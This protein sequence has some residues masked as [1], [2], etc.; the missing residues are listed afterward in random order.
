VIPGVTAPSDNFLDLVPVRTLDSTIDASG[1]RVLLKP[2]FGRGRVS[3][4]WISLIG[5]RRSV[6]KIH[7]DDMG[8][9][10]WEA[11]DG[12]RTVA[13]IADVV[14]S[15]TDGPV[16]SRYERCSIFIKRLMDA[17]AVHVRPSPP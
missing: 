2:K 5:E 7:L 4:W 8:T 14:G 9:R 16:N 1:R 6:L 12:T 17:G 10:T 13:D 11:I 3:T 15:A